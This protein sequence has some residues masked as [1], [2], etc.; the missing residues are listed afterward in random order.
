MKNKIKAGK[1]YRLLD[2]SEKV[3]EGDEFYDPHT[4]IWSKSSNWMFRGKTQDDWAYRRKG[5]AIE[6]WAVIFKN[7]QQ[8]RWA[9]N[10]VEGVIKG[11]HKV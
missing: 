6:G 4:K 11:P 9:A 2:K 10:T 3:R 7:R 5:D 1:G 8:A